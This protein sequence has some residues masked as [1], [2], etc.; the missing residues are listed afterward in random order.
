MNCQEA[1]DLMG[2]AI[3]GCLAPDA[4]VGLDDHLAECPPCR[5]YLDQLR[6]TRQALGHLPAP[7]GAGR[8]RDEL[9]E[10]FRKGLRDRG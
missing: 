3:D 4:V 8:R 10:K 2:D 6:L 1:I 7:G 9:I 5:H